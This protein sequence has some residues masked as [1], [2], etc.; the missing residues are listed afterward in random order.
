M[1]QPEWQ[2]QGWLLLSRSIAQVENANRAID[3]TDR[4]ACR[5]GSASESAKL[6]LTMWLLCEQLDFRGGVTVDLASEVN[7]FDFRAGPDFCLHSTLL[8]H[9][10]VLPWC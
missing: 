7:L 4:K 3:S 9:R 6:P 2:N 5:E 10:D 8:S 1:R